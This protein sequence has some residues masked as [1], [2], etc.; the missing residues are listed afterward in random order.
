ML[1]DTHIWI[2]WVNGDPQLRPEHLNAISS[3][4]Q[5]GIEISII[6]CW[7]VAK[8]VENQRLVL[9]LP[10]RD[11][12]NLALSFPGIRLLPLTLDILIEST[13]LPGTFH[14][15]P[16]DQ[17]VVATARVHQLPLLTFDLKILAY[18]DVTLVRM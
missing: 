18:P 10:V 15:D 5:T 13:Q 12:L 1:L 11:W 8:L 16:A 6:S 3:A 9:S 4:Q 17:I 14:K 2:W 7:E